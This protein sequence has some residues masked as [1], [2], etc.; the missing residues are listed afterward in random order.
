MSYRGIS[1][2][3]LADHLRPVQ[4]SAMMLEQPLAGDEHPLL[5][6]LKSTRVALAGFQVGTFSDPSAWSLTFCECNA[7]KR[8]M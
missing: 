2:N 4:L 1:L 5:L 8:L 3:C 7:R 6:E